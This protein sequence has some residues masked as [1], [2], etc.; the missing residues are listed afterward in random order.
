MVAVQRLNDE[1]NQIIYGIV[2]NGKVWQFGKLESN[3]FTRN[4]NFY[5]I[6]DLKSLFGAVN[7]VFRQCELQVEGKKTFS[8]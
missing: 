2:S 5:T 3:V 7:Y 1:A 4:K 8:V 6:Q